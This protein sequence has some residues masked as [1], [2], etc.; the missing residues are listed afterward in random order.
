MQSY[1]RRLK[2]LRFIIKVDDDR[3]RAETLGRLEHG[4]RR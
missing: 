1:V 3:G 2:N 4:C